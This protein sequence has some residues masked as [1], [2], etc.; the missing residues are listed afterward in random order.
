MGDEEPEIPF[1]TSLTVG[2]LHSFHHSLN[3]NNTPSVQGV[4]CAK[5]W[6]DCGE[7]AW[8]HDLTVRRAVMIQY[9]ECA[10]GGS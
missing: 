5:S 4:L 3:E 1:L 7:Q 6:K 2:R 8:L 9:L 10:D